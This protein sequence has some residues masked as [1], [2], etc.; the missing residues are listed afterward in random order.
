[1]KSLQETKESTW[2]LTGA[3]DLKVTEFKPK[4]PK[5]ITLLLHGHNERGLRIF[6]KLRNFL[7]DDTY[8]LA[9]NAPFPLPR[10]KSDR[11]DFGYTWYFYDPFTKSYLIDQGLAVSLLKDLL[12]QANPHGLPITIIGFSQGGYLAPLI[13]YAEKNTRHVL[14]IGCEFRNRFFTS[15]PEFTIDALHGA[16]D[17][18]IQPEHAQ[19]EISTLKQLGIEVGWHLIAE[20][21]HEINNEVGSTLKK[22]LEQYGEDSL[23]GSN[24]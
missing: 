1:M 4:S 5:S 14:G 17:T 9:P 8:I 10:I 18:I 21:K 19:T 20:T 22:I 24:R 13:A 7:S 11:V 6:R 15:P 3:W 16:L 12:K 23:S 2:N